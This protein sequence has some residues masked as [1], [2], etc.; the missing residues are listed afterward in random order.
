MLGIKFIKENEE[1]V[2]ENIKKKFQKEKIS[3][4][5][6]II[7]LDEKWRKMKYDEDK[8]RGDRNKISKEI[9]EL[10]KLGKDVKKE[11]KKAT[12]IPGKI[13]KSEEKRKKLEK[14]IWKI[15]TEIPNII[16]KR[17]PIGKNSSENVEIKKY[18][19]PKKFSFKVKDHAQAMEDLGMAD[20]DSSARVSGTGFYYLEDKIALLNMALINYARDIMVKKGYRYIETPLLLREEIIDSVTDLNDKHNMIYLVDDEPKMA[21]IGTSEHS[22][23]GRF[24][25]QEINEKG[26]PIK[27]TSYSMC[28]RKEIG[29][30]GL[31]EKGLFRA[32]QFNKVEMIVIC[33]PDVKE[34]EK[35]Y[36][37]MQDI[38]IEVF[39]GLEI[40][41]RIL[42]ICSGDL[43]DLK[44]EQIDVE[45][46]SPR[47]NKYYEVGSCS[48][49]TE[50]QARK[51]NITT[52]INGERKIPHTLN[53]TV[54]ATSRALKAI[55]E[56]HQQKDGSI[57]IP[58][59][60]WKYTRFKEIKKK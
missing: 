24:V 43:G 49:L 8:L 53:N 20:F 27:H 15:Q 30:H 21:L 12:N 41:T 18:G 35:F 52:R 6:K 5:D 40:P 42:K 14:E 7:E 31:D 10:K 54:I 11:M 23:I 2:K 45:A 48:N 26:L 59:A 28:F 34:S 32:H 37:E 19:K 22:M 58:K 46:W 13:N 1:F 39:K 55:I 57:K 29:S 16:S 17:V 51:L 9:N 44:Y 4:V 36:Q 33:K 56:N 3:L 25:N 47:T 38:T 60:L 50:S